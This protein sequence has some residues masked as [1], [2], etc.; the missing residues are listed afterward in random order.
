MGPR[1]RYL[2]S[3]HTHQGVVTIPRGCNYQREIKVRA[4]ENTETFENNYTQYA[5]HKKLKTDNGKKNNL[6]KKYFKQPRSK[7][8]SLYGTE[9][10][11]KTDLQR[12]S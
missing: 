11:K 6:Q 5:Y 4:K 8:Q 10:T 12:S 1:N 9:A 3:T 7:H 2:I